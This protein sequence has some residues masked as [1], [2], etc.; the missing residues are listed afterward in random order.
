MG[1]AWERL[2]RSVK[3]SLHVILKEHTPKEETLLTTLAEIEHS[4]NS[5]PLTLVSSDTQEKEALTPNYFLI[6]TSSATINLCQSMA[7]STVF[8]RCILASF[9]P[10]IFAFIIVS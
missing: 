5:C 3:E 7:H 8:C 9:V 4:V 10:G 1:G 2:I 6:G